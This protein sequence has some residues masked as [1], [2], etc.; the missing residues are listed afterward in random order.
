MRRRDFITTLGTAATWPLAAI[1]QRPVMPVIGYLESGTGI[2]TPA[3][4]AG[5]KESGFRGGK[6]RHHRTPGGGGSI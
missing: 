2:I 6:E 1:A 4:Y 5:L 3:F